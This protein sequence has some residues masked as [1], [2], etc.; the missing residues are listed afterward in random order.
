MNL[1]IK[2]HQNGRLYLFEPPDSSNY[3]YINKY[4]NRDYY[5]CYKYTNKYNFSIEFNT[6]NNRINYNY[7]YLFDKHTYCIEFKNAGGNK[8]CKSIVMNDRYYTYV[9]SVTYELIKNTF[10]VYSLYKYLLSIKYLYKYNNLQYISNI[11]KFTCMKNYK[12]II[13]ITAI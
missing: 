12:I 8:I 7:C 5:L 13:Y 9:Y 1:D 11:K 4:K 3:I 10:N 6:I 2:I